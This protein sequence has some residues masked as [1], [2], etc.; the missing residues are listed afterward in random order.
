M[1]LSG[2]GAAAGLVA[3]LLPLPVVEGLPRMVGVL[4]LV[5]LAGEARMVELDGA[6]VLEVGTCT[7]LV[8]VEGMCCEGGVGFEF[9]RSHV[10]GN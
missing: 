2:S 1:A 6:V 8:M 4:L 3:L 10:L 9:V 5:L 7:M